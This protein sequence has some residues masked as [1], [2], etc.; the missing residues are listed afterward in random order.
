[1]TWS[2]RT[3]LGAVVVIV[4]AAAIVGG[5]LIVG[6]P[7][8]ARKQR[9]DERR[10]SDLQQIQGAVNVAY[11]RTRAMPE[12]MDAAMNVQSGAV[13]PVDPG[14][15][16]PYEYRALNGQSFELC[17]VFE[18][19]SPPQAGAVDAS[20]AHAAGRQCFPLT[21]RDLSKPPAPTR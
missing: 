6:S 19:A 20:W 13:A 17:A 21:A 5:L 18:R 12:T 8:E 16:R 4:A 7:E 1:M 9:L 15:G 11:T 10:V 14:T 2:F 3:V